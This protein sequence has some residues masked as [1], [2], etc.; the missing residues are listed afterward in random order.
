MFLSLIH[1][2]WEKSC[3]RV[4]KLTYGVEYNLAEFLQEEVDEFCNVEES[5]D[6]NSERHQGRMGP[7]GFH[8]QVVDR[9][10]RSCIGDDL[11]LS[12]AGWIV[13]L[14]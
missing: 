3:V 12:R 1:Y 4:T 5:F 6:G 14:T 10:P 8:I 9:H 7:P 13:C 11:P 2:Q